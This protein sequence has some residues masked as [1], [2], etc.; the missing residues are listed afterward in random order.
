MSV[1]VAFN[2]YVQDCKNLQKDLEG[3]LDDLRF[4]QRGG[5]VRYA[6]DFS[7][8][9]SYVFPEDNLNQMRIF[10]HD[11]DEQARVIQQRAFHELFVRPKRLILLEPYLI[12]FS[13]WDNRVRNR[14]FREVVTLA[15]QAL[16]E[17]DTL[18]RR[19]ELWR[20][21][22]FISL[23]EEK[24]SE[25]NDSELREA[26]NFIE[27][28]AVHLVKLSA[29]HEPLT[30][31]NNLLKDQ[32]F[33]SLD[34]FLGRHIEPNEGTTNRWYRE[35]RQRRKAG[36]AAASY[37]DAIAVAIVQVTNERMAKH[38]IRVCLVTSSRHM[39][40]VED[41]LSG[42]EVTRMLRHPRCFS[43][44]SIFE[45]EPNAVMIQKI[46]SMET[47]V[48]VFLESNKSAPYEQ[49]SAEL[50]QDIDKIAEQWHRSTG[51]AISMIVSASA[52][53]RQSN[54]DKSSIETLLTK[55]KCL[56]QLMGSREKTREQIRARIDELTTAIE[57]D[58]QVLGL[59]I[60]EGSAHRKD[61]LEKNLRYQVNEK[62]SIL[63]SDLYA[64][65]YT[66]QF[67]SPALSSWAA[68]LKGKQEISWDDTIR[69]FR[70]GIE[71]D[72]GYERLLFIAY[73]FG[74]WN[75]WLVAEMYCELALSE[76]EEAQKI[77]GAIPPQHEALFFSAVC[78]RKH[79]PT[80]DRY[81]LALRRLY[82]ARQSRK[83]SLN[84]QNYEDPR[85]LKEQAA[86]ILRW[87]EKA[88][89][90]KEKSLWKTSDL[91]SPDQAISIS[92]QALK[93][94]TDEDRGL[95]SQIYNN[96]CYH[97]SNV[98]N[99]RANNITREYLQKFEDEQKHE[100]DLKRWPPH[101]LDTMVWAR[102]KIQRERLSQQEYE[103]LIEHLDTA[104][105][106]PDLLEED[107]ELYRRHREQIRSAYRKK[108]E[109]S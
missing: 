11:T 47:S 15:A 24:D 93:S 55:Y 99:E 86:L 14:Y 40:D 95:K 90:E 67:F 65:P 70:Q 46:A 88:N 25:I 103:K 58:Y 74:A 75:D 2:Q 73:L 19:G 105:E 39:H 7:E 76:Y 23:L 22:K 36:A 53:S 63:T 104:L 10:S 20:I 83:I 108:F 41:L 12:E 6:V 48:R 56:T 51:L 3:F 8:I 13:S 77:S 100:L 109:L 69:M 43:S 64:M 30:R 32:R 52:D 107:K 42:N 28:N 89:D 94:I 27:E 72:L 21:D 61:I 16:G 9:Y 85:F 81:R 92:N 35:L 87:N 82:E 80:P 62:K 78:L 54:N 5:V 84:D 18:I 45:N 26:I 101:Y 1:S 37:L 68:R 71:A 4:E 59:G 96:L 34:K 79:A 97:F 31:L 49:D 66:L 106:Y 17:A 60:H 38:K 50:Q 57:R 102:W 98:Q 44:L 91:P 33:D 29:S